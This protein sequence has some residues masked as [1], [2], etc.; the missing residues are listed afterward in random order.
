MYP[1]YPNLKA[2]LQDDRSAY[3]YFATLPQYVRE[4]IAERSDEVNSMSSL[5]S[6]VENATK[7]DG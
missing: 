1:K 3:D 4:H 5:V 7:G 2:L 6:H